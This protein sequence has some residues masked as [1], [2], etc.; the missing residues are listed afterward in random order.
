AACVAATGH[1]LVALTLALRA[2]FHDG[3]IAPGP[4]ESTELWTY[5]AAWALFGAG[6][7]AYGAVRADAVLRWCGLAILFATAAKVF[8]LD[9]ARLSGI[10][11]VASLLGLAAVAT[12]TAL[13]MRR[14]RA[15]SA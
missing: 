5:S 3:A 1:L 13:A 12:L 11:R 2:V 8:A 7:L 4:A 14:L 6:A 9:T 15:R 10:I